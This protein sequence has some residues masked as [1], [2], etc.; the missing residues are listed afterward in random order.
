MLFAF[1]AYKE[2]FATRVSALIDK[3]VELKMLRLQ[4]ERLAD[5]VL[6]APEQEEAASPAR[7]S[8]EIP[9]IEL[10]ELSFAYSD[11]EADVLCG[12]NLRI[13]PGESVAIVGPS[14]CGKTTLLKLILGIHAPKSG[15]ML[16]GG[17]PLSQLGL[18][19]W[20]DMVGVVMQDEPLFSGS[21]SDNICFF[22]LQPDMDWVMH[23]ARVASVHDEIEA[24]PMGYHT[25]IGD[26]GSSLSGGQKQR[27]LLARALYKRPKIL[28]LDEATSALD[29]DGERLVNQAV[30][31][32]AL[33]RVIVAHRP[34]T[35][36]SAGRV[37][38]LQGG[39]VAQDLR[40][41]GGNVTSIERGG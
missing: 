20:R 37:V 10:R 2:Q 18:R 27:I 34:E 6:T 36:A 30:R 40:S 28:L 25:L 38:A 31:Q 32:L 13:E 35:I 19:A 1:F 7:K 41:V 14:G 21:I 9:V 3:V 5:I 39:R 17:V 29:V 11:A 26:M 23:C 12:V 8:A 33:T 15:E 16:I 22:D 24:M 4:G